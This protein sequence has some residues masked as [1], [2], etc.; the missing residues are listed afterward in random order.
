MN[1]FGVTPLELVFVLVL[2][3]IVLG[4][5]RLPEAGRFIGRQFAKLLAWQQ[6]SPEAQLVQQLR[7]EF[8]DEIV[9]LRDELVHARQQLDVSSDIKQLQTQTQALMKQ[10]STGLDQELKEIN[11]TL[12][13][14]LTSKPAEGLDAQRVPSVNRP[15]KVVA[16]SATDADV[17]IPTDVGDAPDAASAPEAPTSNT[18]LSSIKNETPSHAVDTAQPVSE[19]PVS[20][21]SSNGGAAALSEYEHMRAQIRVIQADLQAMQEHMRARNL[22]DADWQPPSSAQQHET[23]SS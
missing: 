14:P 19:Q 15:N 16:R 23:I 9:S 7:K 8:E 2:G 17:K 13:S 21:A 4:P 22:I 11:Q 18:E 5:E 3:L 20:A 10:Q 6:Q 12:K 1:F